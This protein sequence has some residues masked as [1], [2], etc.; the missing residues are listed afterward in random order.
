MQ[1]IKP[2]RTAS[3]AAFGAILVVVGIAAL[4]LQQSG[5][6]LV[7]T[8]SGG[9]WPFI[10][11]LPGLVLLTGAWV[12]APSEGIG[13]ARAGAIVTTVGLI[14]LYAQSTEH[15]ERW[16]YL[17]ALLPGAAGVASV[18][19]GAVTARRELVGEGLRAIA[20]SAALLGVG[21]WFF[22]ALFDTGQPPVDIGEAWPTALIGIGVLVLFGAVLGRSRSDARPIP[23]LTREEQQ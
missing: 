22:E 10:V 5:V 18:V 1:T 7:D 8:L 6:D 14:C 20:I 13:F 17:W 15:W 16:A 19:Y 3:P 23:P 9:G 2:A 11:V 12:A 4:A 21:F